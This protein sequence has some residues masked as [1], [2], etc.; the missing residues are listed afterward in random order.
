[1]DEKMKKKYNPFKMWGS[2]IGII[3]FILSLSIPSFTFCKVV[4]IDDSCDKFEKGVMFIGKFITENIFQIEKTNTFPFPDFGYGITVLVT[5]AVLYFLIG[6][7]IH[8][9][10]RRFRK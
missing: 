6:Y 7:V 4:H 5:N 3:L 9:L 8:S 10:F 1:M 2:W